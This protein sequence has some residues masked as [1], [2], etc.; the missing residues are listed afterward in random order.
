MPSTIN[1]HQALVYVMVTMSAVDRKMSDH[2]LMRIGNIVQSLP[3]FRDFD[4]E[5]LVSVAEECGE[6][7]SEDGGLDAILGL[8]KEALPERLRET[9]YALAVEVA[10]VDLDVQQEE[11]RFLQILRDHLDLDKLTVAAIERAAR[12]RYRTM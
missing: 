12:A 1:P 5:R 8:V 6:I 10:A 7:L 2:E 11:L 3:I 9:A 4:P